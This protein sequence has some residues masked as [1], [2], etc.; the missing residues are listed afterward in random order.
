MSSIVPPRNP[1]D[2]DAA[3][4]PSGDVRVLARLVEEVVAADAAVASAEA[5]RVR[6]LAAAGRFALDA[7]ASERSSVRA[8]EMAMREVASE[9]AAACRLSDRTVQREI[10]DALA[11]VDSFPATMAA[12]ESGVLS[13]RYVRTIVDAGMELP[14]ERRKEFDRA[15][16]GMAREVSSPGR[17]KARLAVAAQRLHPRTITERHRAGRERRCVRVIPG[18]DGMSDLI[19]TLPTV[20]AEAIHDRLMQQA[21]VIVD[22]RAAAPGADGGSARAE[23]GS[24]RA[25]GG[26]ARAEGGSARVDGGSARGL[27]GDPVSGPV[28]PTAD[29]RT[30]EQI[31]ADVFADML[32]TGDPAIDPTR[33]GDGP[34]SLGKIRARIQVVVPALTMLAAGRE[35]SAPAELVGHGPVDAATARA[36]AETTSVPW[37]RVITHPIAGTVL[38]TDTY[39]RSTAI[40]RYLRARDRRCRWPGCTAPAIRCEID[41]NTDW[42][43]GGATDVRNLCCLCQRHHTQKQFTRWTVRQLAGGVIEWTS[44]TG[45]VYIDHLDPYPAAE[46]PPPVRF[47]E[48]PPPWDGGATGAAG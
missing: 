12:W 30:L 7:A 38:H 20:L 39:V 18:A 23:G 5:A 31:R 11:L 17:L 16:V 8:S 9:L 1:S 28:A 13:R 36:L 43:D 27:A 26:S 2:G 14:P 24:A 19:A 10:D 46:A 40:D 6:T 22:A 42:A 33:S 37:D 41:H 21:R 3:R 34:G 29:S 25:E 47:A 32:L 44:P 4:G 35:N 15:A 48:D 45:R